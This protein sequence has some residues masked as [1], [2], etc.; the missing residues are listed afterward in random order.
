[1]KSSMREETLDALGRLLDQ[2]DVRNAFISLDAEGIEVTPFQAAR[3]GAP[4]RFSHDQLRQRAANPDQVVTR[5]AAWE[6][7]PTCAELLAL[8][9][10]ELDRRRCSRA[11]IVVYDD[12]LIVNLDGYGPG[13]MVIYSADGRVN[14]DWTTPPATILTLT[15]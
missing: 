9:G 11:F 3:P 12:L 10:R 2:R 7:Q 5:S 1:M 4:F 14:S 15:R 8:A 6:H 13:E